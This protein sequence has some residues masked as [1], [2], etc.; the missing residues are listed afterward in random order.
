MNISDYILKKMGFESYNEVQQQI[1]DASKKSPSLSLISPTGSGKT[2]AFLRVLLEQTKIHGNGVQMVILVPTRELALQIEKVVGKL[3]LSMRSYCSYGGHSISSEERSLAYAP[4]LLIATPGRLADHIR[5]GNVDLRNVERVVLDEYDKIL[6][7]GYQKDIDFIFNCFRNL[8]GT[9]L[10]SAT[11]IE[12][13]CYPK[14]MDRNGLVIDLSYKVKE[15]KFEAFRVEAEENDKL[16]SLVALLQQI[17][18][19]S[20]MVFCN[21]RDA[22]ERI[23]E[24]LY[25]M[26]VVHEFIHGLRTQDERERSM[27]KFENGTSSIIVGTDLLAR[28][29]DHVE[30]KNV[31]HYQMPYQ[32]DVAVHRNGRTSRGEEE[33]RVFVVVREEEEVSE[34]LQKIEWQDWIVKEST[35]EFQQTDWD[36]LYIG[37]GKKNKINKID[38]VGFLCKNGELEKKE[39]G[40][41]HVKDYRAYVAV[42]R[43]KIKPLIRKISRI[44]IKGKK[45]LFDRAY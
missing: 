19:E 29:I 41:I 10:T 12:D 38:I 25:D 22:V 5:R 30:V 24:A 27:I 18:H 3:Q 33:G 9:I 32:E 34:P 23:S 2:I 4:S 35:T 44:K 28:G 21:H 14:T 37:A 11:K 20:T 45:V 36:T 8:S 13:L 17:G 39:I 40:M 26:G 16:A 7:L 31:I 1:Y 42:P 43:K 6:Q 15:N